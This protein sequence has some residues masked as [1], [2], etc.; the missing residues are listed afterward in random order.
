MLGIFVPVLIDTANES[1][2]SLVI[3]RSQGCFN[4]IN[5]DCSNKNIITYYDKKLQQKIMEAELQRLC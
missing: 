3:T 2:C 4:L 5:I 1:N